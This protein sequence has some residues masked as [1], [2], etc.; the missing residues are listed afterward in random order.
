METICKCAVC[1]KGNII[2]IGNVYTCDYVKSIEEKCSF[3]IFKNFM[4]VELTPEILADLM[5]KGVTDVLTL[6]KKNG[7]EFR[8]RLKL[9]MGAKSAICLDFTSDVLGFPCPKCGRDINITPKGYSCQGYK[10]EGNPCD[11]YVQ[12]QIM[13]VEIP[14]KEI[15]NVI[16]N[17]TTENFYKFHGNKDFLAKLILD[18]NR[19]VSIDSSICFCPKCHTGGIIGVGKVFMCNDENCDFHIFRSYRFKDITIPMLKKLMAG[20]AVQIK[21]ILKKDKSGKYDVT[22]KL[23]ENFE[24]VQL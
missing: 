17:G 9:D 4:G 15:V 5:G 3:S 7:E 16:E 22:I 12:K 13:G 18:D 24:I 14:Q 20:E 19:N 21:G 6:T 23:S 10:D 11:F 1:G 2:D 8:A